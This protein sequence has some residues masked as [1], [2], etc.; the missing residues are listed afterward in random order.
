[1]NESKYYIVIC[2]FLLSYILVPKAFAETVMG[3]VLDKNGSPIT[4]MEIKLFHPESGL[5]RPRY[6]DERGK[7]FF[8]FVRSVEGNYDI[9]Y[10][11]K[12]NLIY[13]GSIQVR[14]NVQLP[15]I[16]F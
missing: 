5:S 16:K 8:D 14:G 1:M 10:Y 13:R 3:Q 9:E 2:I 4:G 6:T 15:S 7:F 11:W 12:G